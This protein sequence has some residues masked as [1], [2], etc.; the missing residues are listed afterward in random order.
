MRQRPRDPARRAH[1]PDAANV[2]T[3][4]SLIGLDWGTS[5]LRAFLFDNEGTVIDSRASAHGIMHLPEGGFTGAFDAV[6][7]EWRTRWPRLPAISAGM[8]GSAHGW[9]EAPYR[10]TPAGIGELSAALSRVAD[11]DLHVVP[12][13]ATVGDRADVMRGEETQIVGALEQC[14]ALAASALLVLPG[15]HS[16]WVQVRDG[17][18][19][20]FTTY[21]TGE[22]FAVLRE[23]STLGRFAKD[24]SCN[25]DAAALSDAFMLGVVAAKRS[26]RGIAPLLFSTRSMVATKQ[27][28]ASISLEY[29]SG[30]LIGDELRCGLDGLAGGARPAALI[31]D[32]ALCGRYIAAL[33]AFEICDV[34]IVD[35]A[36]PV[37]LWHIA[38]RAGL[39]PPSREN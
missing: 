10:D 27:L 32:A 4:P 2:T 35:S 13:I 15:T 8:I 6:T 26:A 5:S 34:P 29:L 22:L 25:A 30:L 21:L 20:N 39:V 17:K 28:A 1:E 11:V 23:H 24:A 31:G 16:K 33:G 9:V 18:V 3:S 7:A 12:G 38:R 36:A 19:D 37:G 14:P